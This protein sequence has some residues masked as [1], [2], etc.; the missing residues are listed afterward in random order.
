MYTYLNNHQCVGTYGHTNILHT[1]MC[2]STRKLN[3]HK[4]C[5]PS[6]TISHTTTFKQTHTV[7]HIHTHLYLRM[8]FKNNHFISIAAG[9]WMLDASRAPINRQR[10]ALGSTLQRRAN[11]QRFTH[12]ILILF[13]FYLFFCTLF[14]LFAKLSHRP[15]MHTHTHPLTAAICTGNPQ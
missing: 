3:S 6:A 2:R 8:S 5:V 14:K 10:R 12:I 4:L 9:C 15:N 1:H 7:V 13:R 11:L